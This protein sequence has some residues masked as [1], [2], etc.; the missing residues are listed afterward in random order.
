MGLGVPEAVPAINQERRPR[1]LPR[2]GSKGFLTRMYVA[3]HTSAMG[4]ITPKTVAKPGHDAVQR[5]G[6]NRVPWSPPGRVIT[7][8]SEASF[9]VRS[10]IRG[11]ITATA[12]HPKAMA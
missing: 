4:K 2:L 1:D 7:G 10:D 5:A 6:N 12:M 3:M 8:R 11:K 9:S